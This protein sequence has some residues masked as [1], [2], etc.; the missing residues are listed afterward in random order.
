MA[1]TL[2]HNKSK[3]GIEW[4]RIKVGGMVDVLL[5]VSECLCFVRD[6]FIR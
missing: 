4:M 5:G 2:R 3:R 6:V 1:G